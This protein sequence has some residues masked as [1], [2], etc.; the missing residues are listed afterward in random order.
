[1]KEILLSQWQCVTLLKKTFGIEYHCVWINSLVKKHLM[2][3][4]VEAAP[5]ESVRIDVLDSDLVENHAESS[6]LLQTIDPCL[7]VNV[8]E[9]GWGKLLSKRKR[10]CL[11]LHFQHFTVSKLKKVI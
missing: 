7:L 3:H 5:L 9:S 2:L 6:K 8:D 4:I 11:C 10:L 1:M